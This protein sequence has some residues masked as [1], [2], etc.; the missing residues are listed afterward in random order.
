[1]TP[2]IIALLL[3]LPRVDLT[4]ASASAPN[5]TLLFQP[6]NP[7]TVFGNIT[8]RTVILQARTA[9]G[10][11]VPTSGDRFSASLFS[12]SPS[13]DTNLTYP[14]CAVTCSPSTSPYTASP[15]CLSSAALPASAL[16]PSSPNW[17]PI[18]PQYT[19]GGQYNITYQTQHPDVY[20]LSISL[21]QPG[22][23]NAAYYDNVWLLPPVSLSR[24]DPQISFNWSS[25]AITPTAVDYVSVRWTGLLV[26]V[27]SELFTLYVTADDWVRVWLDKRLILSAWGGSCC[28]A[29]WGSVQLTANWNHDLIVEYAELRGVASIS[30]QWSSPSTPLQLIP[31][32]ALYYRTPVGG[33][34][35]TNFTI[36]PGS[37]S[38]AN[39]YAYDNNSAL[40]GVTGGLSASTAG[41]STAFL[42]QAVDV[43]GNVMTAIAS[44]PASI[45][46][47]MTG[48]SSPTVSALQYL[49][50]GLYYVNYTAIVS[51]AYS[52]SVRVSGTGIAQSPFAVTVAP[53]ATSPLNC[54]VIGLPSSCTSG[55]T[56]SFYV[57]LR[58]AFGNN[59]SSSAS[60]SLYVVWSNTA[61]SSVSQQGLTAATAS[62]GLLQSYLTPTQSGPYS[63]SVYVDTV[64]VLSSPASVTVSSGSLYAALSTASGLGLLTAVAGQPANF[65]VTSRD[66][67]K[68][69]VIGAGAA[70]FAFSISNAL[71]AVVA[72]STM[73]YTGSGGL[74][75]SSYTLSTAGSYSLAITAT[76]SGIGV[77]GSPFALQVYAGGVAAS[78]SFML[79]PVL[80][81]VVSGLTSTF[82]VQ[83]RDSSGNAV[84]VGG[85]AFSVSLACPSNS[86][87]GSAVDL[88]SGV[89][90]C[91]IT[92]YTA[93]SS[94]CQLYV[95][96][97]GVNISGSPFSVT[98]HPGAATGNSVASGSGLSS[99]QCGSVSAFS[100]TTFD[101]AGNALTTGTASL[102]VTVTSASPLVPSP[103]VSVINYQNGSYLYS[104]RPTVSGSYSTAVNAVV[105]GGLQ[106]SYYSDTGFSVP[107]GSRVDAVVNFTWLSTPPLPG[108]NTGFYSV[109]WTGK[110][111]APYTCL[112]TFYVVTVV[113]TG[114]ALSVN[115]Q[116][117]I[118]ALSPSA[119]SAQVSGSLALT[120]GG[121]Y[122]LQLLYTTTAG[123]GQLQ[124]LWSCAA[125]FPM[126]LLPSSALSHVQS[127]AG[128]PFSTTI[129]AAATSASASSFS[130]SPAS[131]TLTAA[132]AV[133][134][135]VTLRDAYNN[136]QTINTEATLVTATIAVTGSSSYSASSSLFIAGVY[137]VTLTPLA[138]GSATLTVF[139]SGQQVAA[140]QSVTISTGLLYPAFCQLL[141]SSSLSA[142][143]GL[144]QTLIIQTKDAGNN[145]LT[146]ATAGLSLL[147]SFLSPLSNAAYVSYSVAYLS[148]GQYAVSFTAQTASNY[149]VNITVSALPI[150]GS[151]FLL[152]VVPG[153]ASP[154]LTALLSPAFSNISVN[155]LGTLA[156]IAT[157]D[158]YGN[159]ET[160]DS[161]QT[162]FVIRLTDKN[163]TLALT[164]L[165][166]TLDYGNGSYALQYNSSVIG[167]Y[168]GQILMTQGNGLF[169]NYY[170]NRWLSGTPALQ[171]VDANINFNWLSDASL[172]PITPTARDYVSIEWTGYVRPDQPGNYTL[173]INA[174]T[175]ARIAIDNVTL[176]DNFL[177][178]VAGS[179]PVYYEFAAANGTLY[180]VRLDY[181][182]NTG[183]A[184]VQL[185]WSC[186]TCGIGNIVVPSANL[187]PSASTVTNQTIDV[188]VT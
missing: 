129:A 61:N 115:D 164:V 50:G 120:A 177:S 181:R 67:F 64:P 17:V 165:G 123:G 133:T 62:P 116:A 34:P 169:G 14:N 54:S 92:P 154:A 173:W 43:F 69:V 77:Q 31:A 70:V 122:D 101:A 109:A 91:S 72:P 45:T 175:G 127:V 157:F 51:G 103:V 25:G 56:C 44:N 27:V 10:A 21:L 18:L 33:S 172:T 82:Q 57:Q 163:S 38:W 87:S 99:G 83:S 40:L 124:L 4:A 78:Y 19:S 90:N 159:A 42:F 49:Y 46:V 140:A 58:D 97:A 1:M 15:S 55:V 135:T 73:T 138:A 100:V 139:Y 24:I 20:S 8:L 28:T 84:T 7:G 155:T 137:T 147:A 180:D 110:L 107:S 185:N 118:S 11:N 63:V 119:G 187:Y 26:P 134:I 111:S 65:T 102:L 150:L 112:Y 9:L 158:S 108:M 113:N 30:L 131:A 160:R 48:P 182:H 183:N 106:G 76:G 104:Y 41:I 95:V 143:A 29:A 12:F 98:V 144:Q 136:V 117:V 86:T 23:L 128:S 152:T 146:A 171:R 53:A 161:Q 6:F 5:S 47:A 168:A 59:R 126:Q 71:G 176:M 142:T 184:Y 151:P 75:F 13:C 68:N 121:L 170:S 186:S 162:A 188:F 96:S 153:I 149:S 132:T 178:T 52:L 130:V 89:Y 167:E 36:A 141:N 22:G 125:Y 88:G 114:V 156:V 105:P 145:S 60:D 79:P 179:W 66:Q 2:L 35:Y 74:Y 94:P 32:S 39:S 166:Q 148:L 93:S 3:L 81:S 174:S 80:S 85:S 16:S 37:P